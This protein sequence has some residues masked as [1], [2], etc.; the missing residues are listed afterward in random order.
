MT[1]D[2]I[3]HRVFQY[4]QDA[5]VTGDVREGS[6]ELECILTPNSKPFKITH[7][8]DASGFNSALK[9]LVEN[10]KLSQLLSTNDCNVTLREYDIRHISLGA[11]LE[12][13]PAFQQKNFDG[14]LSELIK[15]YLLDEDNGTEVVLKKLGLAPSQ[16]ESDI[17]ASSFDCFI[18]TLQRLESNKEEQAKVF[19]AIKKRYPNVH[20]AVVAKKIDNYRMCTGDS[21]YDATLRTL[22][23]RVVGQDRVAEFLASALV[24]GGKENHTFLFVGPTGVGKTEM[25]KAVVAAKNS[26]LVMIPMN[27][28]S[29]QFSTTTLYGDC[30]VIYI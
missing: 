5:R 9:K 29:Q 18:S 28:Y 14:D 16:L 15:S 6:F 4:F 30:R 11:N 12:K 20:Q 7:A 24:S 13:W 25:A 22:K 19:E 27:Q 1:P 10:V 23:D 17:P 8:L 21:T 2:A 26:G 3:S